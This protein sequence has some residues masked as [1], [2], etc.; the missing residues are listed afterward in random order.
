MHLSDVL[1]QQ[2]DDGVLPFSILKGH[3]DTE[4]VPE[5]DG[6][7]W[8]GAVI[9]GAGPTG[10]GAT[11]E[12][13]HLGVTLYGQFCAYF[14]CLPSAYY[15]VARFPADLRQA[16]ICS[17]NGGGQNTQRTALVCA[18]M[19]ATHGL[20]SIPRSWIDGLQGSSEIVEAARQIAADA[21]DPTLQPASMKHDQWGWCTV[22][23]AR[24]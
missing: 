11:I 2:A 16:A 18:L 17:L 15:C 3:R 12:P 7:L 22:L 19:G 24:M 9:K 23:A 6:L 20:S 4:G 13:A 1:Y 5:P 8:F 21:V 14:A 10:I